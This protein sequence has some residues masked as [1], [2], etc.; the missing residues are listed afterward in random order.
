MLTAAD[1][2]VAEDQLKRVRRC[3]LHGYKLRRPNLGMEQYGQVVRFNAVADSLLAEYP[4][5]SLEDYK[6]GEDIGKRV[7]S[8]EGLL[9][10]IKR[11]ILGGKKEAEAK[12]ENVP[13]WQR[14][15]WLDEEVE[16]LIE[17]YQDGSGQI[18]I[19]KSYAPFF[20]ANGKLAAALKADTTQ[21]KSA[22]TKAKP[23]LDR[24][25]AF[26]AD[27]ERQF[28]PFYGEPTDEK[29]VQFAKVLQGINAKCTRGL[30]DKWVD[31]GYNY[32][33]WGKEPFLSVSPSTGKKMFY[34]DPGLPNESGPITL[35]RPSKSELVAMVR[36]LKTLCE[37]YAVVEQYNDD[38]GLMG[39]DFTD[40]P[41]RGYYDYPEVDDVLSNALWGMEIYDEF[42]YYFIRQLEERI[43]CLG[44][45]MIVYLEVVLK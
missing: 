10:S 4:S 28:K 8:L 45:A 12:K 16:G 13:F 34:Y 26:L 29:A 33:G 36:E 17:A 1:I 24:M 30:A 37:V 44:E 38:G 5:V 14:L 40:P 7:V 20:P 18:T 6:S 23:E 21:Y 27:I 39:L 25:K 35:P 31:T 9:D 32:L 11:F 41:I 22:F 43:A 2:A 3:L 19:P 15:V 42:G